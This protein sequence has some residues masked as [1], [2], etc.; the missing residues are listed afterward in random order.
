M[1]EDGGD[2]ARGAGADDLRGVGLGGTGEEG[3]WSG[4]WVAEREV[5]VGGLGPRSPFKGLGLLG[6]AGV[7]DWDVRRSGGGVDGG[8][9][10]ARVGVEG[11]VRRDREGEAAAEDRLASGLGADGTRVDVDALLDAR[12]APIETGARNSGLEK[13]AWEREGAWKGDQVESSGLLDESTTFALL[14]KRRRKRE[15]CSSGRPL[16]VS[17]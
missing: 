14:L 17:R 5:S 3:C 15:R 10:V 4:R 8:R 16:L 13:V 7:R 1:G 9:L 2:D 11:D 6:E 12:A